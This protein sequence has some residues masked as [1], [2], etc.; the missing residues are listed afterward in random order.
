ME[1]LVGGGDAWAEWCD[2]CSLATYEIGVAFWG[3]NQWGISARHEFNPRDFV[4]YPLSG[5]DV[6]RVFLNTRISSVTAHRRWFLG[7]KTEFDIGFGIT[8]GLLID[9][10]FLIGVVPFELLVGRKLSRRV[11]IK[12]GYS[13]GL[14]I[15]ERIVRRPKV[16]GFA[17]IGF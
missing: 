6:K 13:H 9:D 11:G 14:F 3:R 2:V 17:V 15:G 1:L 12:A 8:W 5:G 16:V 7:E 4:D 10:E